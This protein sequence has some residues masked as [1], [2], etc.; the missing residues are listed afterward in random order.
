MITGQD[1]VQER[2][3]CRPNA[4]LIVEKHTAGRVA[5][6]TTATGI[7]HSHSLRRAHVKTSA[8][9]LMPSLDGF[10]TRSVRL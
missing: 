9:V 5:V 6:D 8:V 4:P 2:L 10:A 3:G 7:G 1:S